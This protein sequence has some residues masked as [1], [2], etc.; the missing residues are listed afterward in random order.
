MRAHD[1]QALAARTLLD[2]SDRSISGRDLMMVWNAIG[3]TGEAGECAELVKKGVLHGHGLDTDKLSKELGDVLWYVAAL[4]T[5]AGL[6]LGGIMAS[7]IDKLRTRYPDGFAQ[8]D[9]IA[10][11]D[12]G[13]E[14]TP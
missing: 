2:G 7:N 9:S 3:L 10:R 5:T 11:V 12:V 6:S 13:S 14:A 4:A 1:Y 8:A